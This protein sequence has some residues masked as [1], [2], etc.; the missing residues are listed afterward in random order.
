[1]RS[2]LNRPGRLQDGSTLVEVRFAHHCGGSFDGVIG[3][4]AALGG[5]GNGIWHLTSNVVPHALY[6]TEFESF[7]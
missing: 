5:G 2:R 1:M 7:E 6:D 4:S 3:W